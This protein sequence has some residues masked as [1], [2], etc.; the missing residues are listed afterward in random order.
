LYLTV[1]PVALGAGLLLLIITFKPLFS[2]IRKK[3]LTP[4][5]EIKSIELTGK[6]KYQRVAVTVD[7]S[8]TDTHALN[9]AITQGGP[10]ASY[11]LIHIVESAGAIVFGS[12]VADH[13]TTLDEKFLN[14]YLKKLQDNGYKTELKLGHGNPKIAI[15][16]LVK[17]FNADVLVMA[18]HGHNAFMDLLLGTTVD[19]VRHKVE[20]PVII[21]KNK[22]SGKN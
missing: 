11:C 13:E 8:A 10:E 19:K 21:V 20:I 12:D 5:G 16:K 18:A 22:T 2:K 9:T 4:H 6:E 1:V 15:P 7:F 3:S 14:D 17:E